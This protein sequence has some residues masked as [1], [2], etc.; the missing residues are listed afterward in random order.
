MFRPTGHRLRP[1]MLPENSVVCRAHG[2]S[3][4]AGP[5]ICISVDRVAHMQTLTCCCC[6]MICRR[7]SA[8]SRGGTFKRQTRPESCALGPSEALAPDIH[9]IWCRR[10]PSSPWCLQL[11]VDDVEE[12]A[13]VYR[14]DARIRRPVAELDGPASNGEHRVLSP[15]VQLL[16]KS[17]S[18]RPKDEAFQA[19]LGHLRSSQRSW[20]RQSLTSPRHPWLPFL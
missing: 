2:G 8:T 20:L 18:V 17:A 9:D 14:R 15:E 6:V 12:G 11:M 10:S 7:S 5:S 19:M 3:P 1:R 4:V 13:W 16:Y